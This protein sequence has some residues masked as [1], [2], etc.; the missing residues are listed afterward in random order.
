MIK[1]PLADSADEVDAERWRR[2]V[3]RIV[4]GVRPVLQH[5]REGVVAGF[6]QV[7]ADDDRSAREARVKSPGLSEIPVGW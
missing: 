1:Q 3:H 4:F 7:V 6:D 5:R 2:V